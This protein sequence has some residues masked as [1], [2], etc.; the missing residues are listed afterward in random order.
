MEVE[1]GATVAIGCNACIPTPPEFTQVDIDCTPISG[2]GPFTYTWL[3]RREGFNDTVLDETGSVLTVTEEG[4]YVCEVSNQDTTL[5]IT[6]TTI[7]RRKL[8]CTLLMGV[9]VQDAPTLSETKFVLSG[10][11][12][13]GEKILKVVVA[14]GLWS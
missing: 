2:D 7:V 1:S 11:F 3:L 14:G 9:P 13:L 6:A 12:C 10:I 5:P 4:E 8:I